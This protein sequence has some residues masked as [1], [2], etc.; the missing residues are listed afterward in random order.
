MPNCIVTNT[1][2]FKDL[3][4][5]SGLKSIKLEVMM[6][7]WMTDNNTEVWP[8]LEQLGVEFY[9]DVSKVF[10]KNENYPI[11]EQ[12]AIRWIFKINIP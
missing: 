1:Q 4:E 5:K 11:L 8:T 10:E 3:V 9:K 12:K 2:Q 6:D 7:K